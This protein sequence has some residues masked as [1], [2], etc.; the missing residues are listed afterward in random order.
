VTESLQAAGVAG[1][2]FI[3][4]GT[5]AKLAKF[6][7]LNPK[8]PKELAFVDDSPTFDA[9]T[10]AGFGMLGE[11]IPDISMPKPPGFSPAMWW[12]YITN[13]M[14]LSPIPENPSP[15]VSTFDGVRR[16]GGTFVLD[17]AAVLY[18]YADPIP[19]EHPSVA[20]VL[21]AAGVQL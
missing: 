15:S 13:V 9:Y 2:L 18:A 14:Q 1:P 17:D 4:V 11:S 6:L 8:V 12:S 3:S 7:E 21:K 20:A 5:G 10:A 16:L 19:G